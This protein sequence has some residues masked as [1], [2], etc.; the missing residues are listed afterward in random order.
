MEVVKLI[1]LNNL[2]SKRQQKGLSQ[3]KLAT[4]SRVS[5]S[6]ISELEVGKKTNPSMDTLEK[7]ATAL[8][9]NVKDLFDN[10]D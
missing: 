9:V 4:K 8:E 2:K 6:Y 5:K 3:S 1:N 10:N 7:L